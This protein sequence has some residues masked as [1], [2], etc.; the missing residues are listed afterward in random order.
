[1]PFYVIVSELD[2]SNGPTHEHLEH[3]SSAFPA[4]NQLDRQ[5]SP[6]GLTGRW[7]SFR[8]YVKGCTR[9]GWG[10]KNG[11]IIVC[12]V[13]C[14]SSELANSVS[15]T[16]RTHRTP[17]EYR[18]IFETKYLKKFQNFENLVLVLNLF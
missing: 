3:V 1:M 8:P 7:P 15:N 6:S 16:C 12:L 14:Q 18:K 11:I 17:V 9:K 5:P 10:A 13:G 4:R 2:G